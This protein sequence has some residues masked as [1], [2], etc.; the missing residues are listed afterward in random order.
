MFSFDLNLYYTSKI[1]KSNILMFVSLFH[2]GF[3]GCNMW[4]PNVYIIATNPRDVRFFAFFIVFFITL[5]KCKIL[6]KKNKL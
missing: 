3:A 6:T 1:N 4:A 2:S 5:L